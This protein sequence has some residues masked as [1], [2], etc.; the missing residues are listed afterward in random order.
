MT[1]QIDSIREIADQF[2]VIVLDQWGV[3]HDGRRPYREALDAVAGL[4]GTSLAVLSNSGKRAAPNAARIASMGFDVAA[5]D[6]IMTSGEALWR[7]FAAG[8]ATARCLFPIEGHTG[9]ASAWAEGG[10]IK[11]AP[12]AEN[13]EALLLMGLPDGSQEEDYDAVLKTA[14]SRDLP[15]Y[16]SNPDL[17]SPRGDGVFVMSPGVLARRYAAMGGTT[18]L[19]GKPHLPIFEALQQATGCA[20]EK[21]LMVGD[22]LHHDIAGAQAAGWASL[23]IC[24]GVHAPDISPPTAPRD[25]ARLTA[26][27]GVAAPNFALPELR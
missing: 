18:H 24:G 5:F 6:H 10:S 4:S 23:L 11:I 8:Q 9:D 12:N 15:L 22:S 27:A 16:C 7:A 14:L 1:R 17:K 20:P 13:A 3:L 2:D 21:I 19:Y 25:I 26:A